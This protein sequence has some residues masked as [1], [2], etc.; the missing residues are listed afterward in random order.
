MSKTIAVV[1]ST[2]AEYGL[3]KRT[4]VSLMADEFFEVRVVVTGAHLMSEQGN[5][6]REVEDDGIPIHQKIYIPFG[7]DSAK[8]KSIFIA[9]TIQQFAEYFAKD[10]PDA[11]MVLGDRYEILA[12]CIAAMNA[13]IPIFHLCGG[14][15]T[16][17]AIDECIRHSITK[18]S[19]LHFVES[20]EYRKRVIQLGEDPERVYDVGLIGA[21]NI[22]NMSFMTREQLSEDLNMDLTSKYCV[23]TFHP[24]TLSDESVEGQVEQLL[25]A[26]SSFGDWQFVITKSNIDA[27]GA[28]INN[29]FDDYVKDHSNCKLFDSLGSKRYLSALKHCEM[30]I[31][32]SSSGVLEAP[33]LGVPTINIGDRQ[34]GRMDKRSIIN[35][36]PLARDIIDSIEK[37]QNPEFRKLVREDGESSMKGSPSS[38]IARICKEQLMNGIAIEKAFYDL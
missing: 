21:E 20:E 36:R 18:M 6:V 26:I 33:V 3:L 14:E 27:G 23:V 9:Q 29:I 1:S 28:L 5:T 15:T 2:R 8:D 38:V 7:G 25:Q 32:N 12:V 16:Q 34:K 35:C 13:R 30:V 10:R 17:G 22:V 31:G 4:I 24:E 37:A 19:F 11:V